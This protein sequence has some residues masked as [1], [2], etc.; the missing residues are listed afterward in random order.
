M[1]LM[2]IICGVCAAVSCDFFAF[3]NDDADYPTDHLPYSLVNATRFQLGLFHYRVLETTAT[4]PP[5]TFYNYRDPPR[6]EETFCEPYASSLFRSDRTL[7]MTAQFSAL[8]APVLGL[9][10]VITQCC[11]NRRHRAYEYQWRCGS[12]LLLG[13]IISQIGTFALLFETSFW[14]VISSR[15][16]RSYVLKS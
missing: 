6:A 1:G 4:L 13:A 15:R 14:Y 16:S 11:A 10:S 2:G 3:Q 8:V 12:L 9:L 7:L 5:L